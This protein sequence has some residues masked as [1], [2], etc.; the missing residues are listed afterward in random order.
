MADPST[1]LSQHPV[2]M[3]QMFSVR[4]VSYS[5]RGS[6]ILSLP[7]PST[8]SYGL[9]SFCYLAS[10]LWNSLPENYRTLSSY[11]GFERLIR[12]YNFYA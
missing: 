2:Y 11:K 6:N 1:R 12:N 3:K 10:E 5:L 7:K 8:A 9:N 4:S